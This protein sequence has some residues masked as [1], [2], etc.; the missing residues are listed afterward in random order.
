[1]KRYNI[2]KVDIL[3]NIKFKHGLPI[4]YSEEIFNHILD[5]IIEGLKRD[6]ILK[7]TGFGTFRLLNKSARIGRNPKIKSNMR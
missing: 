5:I 7:I 2:S 6:G 1:M 3:K 4:S